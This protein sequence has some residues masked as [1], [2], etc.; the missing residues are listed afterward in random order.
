MVTTNAMFYMNYRIADL[1]LRQIF[2]EHIGVGVTGF[3]A[4]TLPCG[5]GKELGFCNDENAMGMPSKTI[6]EW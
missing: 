3:F 2:E 6:K 1:K 5:L 4:P